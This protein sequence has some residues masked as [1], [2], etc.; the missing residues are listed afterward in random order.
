MDQVLRCQGY[1]GHASALQLY[2]DDVMA[3]QRHLLDEGIK[4]MPCSH[5]QTNLRRVDDG[6]EL[7][8]AEHA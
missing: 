7:G 8:D 1:R 6:R 5:L 4:D 3:G 2:F